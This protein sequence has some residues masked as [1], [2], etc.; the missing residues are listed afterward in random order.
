MSGKDGAK[1]YSAANLWRMRNFY[2]TYCGSENS[3]H[4][5]EKLVGVVTEEVAAVLTLCYLFSCDCC[6]GC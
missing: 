3:H 6:N 1:G 4:W 2:L 5:C